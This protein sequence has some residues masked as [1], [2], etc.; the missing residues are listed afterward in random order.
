ML[1]GPNQ[2]DVRLRDDVGR[3][4]A[5]LLACHDGVTIT[6]HGLRQNMSGRHP[7]LEA[8]LAGQG[9][10]PI[11]HLM[12]D[13]ATAEISRTQVWQWMRHG[14]QA[15]RRH[16]VVTTE[17]L[18]ASSSRRRDRRFICHRRRRRAPSTPSGRFELKPPTCSSELVTRRRTARLPDASTPTSSCEGPGGHG[19]D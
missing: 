1:T 19:P 18:C 9:C 14:A 3:D 4:A 8:W 11:D 13:A 17:P 5:D 2:L 15:R 7:Y 6:E 12:E 10:V 16:R